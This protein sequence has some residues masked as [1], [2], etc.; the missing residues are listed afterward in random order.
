[1]FYY[2]RMSVFSKVKNLGYMKIALFIICFMPY[3]Q[4]I[5]LNLK[6]AYLGKRSNFNQLFIVYYLAT[7]IS[8]KS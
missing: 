3:K 7:N 8:F 2:L 4:R 5:F 1:M 6:F